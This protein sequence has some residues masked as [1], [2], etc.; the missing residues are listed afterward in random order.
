[1]GVN[2]KFRVVTDR[3]PSSPAATCPSRSPDS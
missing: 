3:T 1:M 2:A